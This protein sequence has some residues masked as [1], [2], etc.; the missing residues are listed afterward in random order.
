MP[1][2]EF[3]HVLLRYVESF[4]DGFLR[5]LDHPLVLIPYRAVFFANVA[6]LARVRATICSR[7]IMDV[8]IVELKDGDLLESIR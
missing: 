7:V 8:V 5:L 4:F 6:D 2:L 1:V 3:V